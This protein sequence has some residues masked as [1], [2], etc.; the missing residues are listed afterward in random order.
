[1]RENAEGSKNDAGE[2][3]QPLAGGYLDVFGDSYAYCG[4]FLDVEVDGPTCA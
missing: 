1:M 4:G 2:K 3:A